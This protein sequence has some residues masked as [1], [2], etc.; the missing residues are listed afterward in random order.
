MQEALGRWP[1][2][3]GL[4]R[5]LGLAYAMAGG[6]RRGA[7]GAH[8][9]RRAAPEDAGAVFVTLRLLFDAFRADAAASPPEERQRMLRYA[10]SY[11]DARGPNQEI[12]ARWLRY[13]EPQK[14]P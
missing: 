2:D 8:R 7:G 13:L 3:D 4:R 14:S 12:V 5:R 1:D 11:V 9:L 6:A 10:R